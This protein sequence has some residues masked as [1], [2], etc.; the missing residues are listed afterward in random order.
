MF[1]R[2][3]Q[4]W[5]LQTNLLHVHSVFLCNDFCEIHTYPPEGIVQIE[6]TVFFSCWMFSIWHHECWIFLTLWIE[7]KNHVFFFWCCTNARRHSSFK[8]KMKLFLSIKLFQIKQITIPCGTRN[9]CSFLEKIYKIQSQKYKPNS[10]FLTGKKPKLKKITF[11]LEKNIYINK[12]ILNN[13]TYLIKIN[14]CIYKS[15]SLCQKS[16]YFKNKFPQK[17]NSS[18]QPNEHHSTAFFNPHA[19]IHF[20]LYIFPF[21]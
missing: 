16:K 9:S 2:L 12:F 15:V 17:H 5:M 7:T 4:S 10:R 19:N 14:W 3:V 11:F 18:K 6:Q 13:F 20:F 1:S 21:L 8:G